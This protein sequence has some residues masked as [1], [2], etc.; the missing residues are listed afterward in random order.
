MGVSRLELLDVDEFD[1]GVELIEADYTYSYVRPSL[2]RCM[3]CCNMLLG[4]PKPTRLG[5]PL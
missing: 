4:V 1:V 3:W 2:L 5:R